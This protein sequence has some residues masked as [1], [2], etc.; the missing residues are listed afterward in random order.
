MRKQLFLLYLIFTVLFGCKKEK[1]E[2]KFFHIPNTLKNSALFQKNSY[3][4]YRNDTTGATDCTY[5]KS[6]LVS[7]STTYKYNDNVDYVI[8]YVK[9]PIQSTL[10]YHF[11]ISGKLGNISTSPGYPF[12]AGMIGFGNGC[13][14]GNTAYVLHDD[15][16]TNHQGENYYNCSSDPKF[17]YGG[18]D[19][20]VELGEYSDFKVN[21]FV[22]DSVR[23]TRSLFY[24]SYYSP[25]DSIDF[26]FSSGKGFVKIVFRVDTARYHTS[27]KRATMS[28]TL[29]R[30]KVVR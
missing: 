20:F 19:K 9:M 17:Y 5:V 8:D 23:V 2:I 27:P 22:F 7:G 13:N 14:P 21:N 29:L 18:G 24:T 28:W 16:L 10:F 11:N 30:Y 6:D 26:Y 12:L 1:Q 4:V 25:N 3:W 15:T